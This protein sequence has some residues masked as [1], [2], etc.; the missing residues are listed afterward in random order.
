MS[1]GNIKLLDGVSSGKVI[2]VV[3]TSVIKVNLRQ[4]IEA[5]SHVLINGIRNETIVIIKVESMIRK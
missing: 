5:P 3:G 4:R 2:F 1:A